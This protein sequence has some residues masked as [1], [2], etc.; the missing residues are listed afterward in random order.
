MSLMGGTSPHTSHLEASRAFAT[1]DQVFFTRLPHWHES[2]RS[3]PA[4]MHTQGQRQKQQEPEEPEQQQ[5]P[6]KQRTSR[7]SRFELVALQASFNAFADKMIS[8]DHPG[9]GTL[10]GFK[11]TQPDPRHRHFSLWRALRLAG[12]DQPV[13]SSME[14][15]MSSELLSEKHK[16]RSV[17]RS[18]EVIH[19]ST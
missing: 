19:L 17:I 11:Y 18:L 12:S 10:E 13:R 3:S 9:K 2:S 16:A 14:P 8:M 7:I 15:L 4:A 5:Q 6:K 1:Q